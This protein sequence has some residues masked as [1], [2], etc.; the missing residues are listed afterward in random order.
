MTGETERKGLVDNLKEERD[1]R[2]NL[3]RRYQWAITALVGVVCFSVG[4][5][6]A[7]DKAAERFSRESTKQITVNTQR[8]TTL[9]QQFEKI[10]NKL[11]L[12]LLSKNMPGTSDQ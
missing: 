11:T 7:A 4:A 8:I 12:L 6:I 3:E 2:G 1:S 9:E 10:D 5:T